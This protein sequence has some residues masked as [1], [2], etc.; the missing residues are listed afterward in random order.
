MKIK[1]IKELIENVLIETLERHIDN[2]P[3]GEINSADDME[4]YL[5]S[6]E[7]D[8]YG[9]DLYWHAGYVRGLRDAINYK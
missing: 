6:L 5:E 2:L 1:K 8:D 7:D 9:D 4:E 3:E